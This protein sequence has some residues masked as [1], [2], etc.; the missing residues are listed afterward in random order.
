MATAAKFTEPKGELSL[1]SMLAKARGLDFAR[2]N[3]FE[4]HIFKPPG[5]HS[6]GG[7]TTNPATGA[8][9]KFTNE[10]MRSFSMRCESIT[11]PFRALTTIEDANIYGPTREIASGI[12]YAGDIDLVFQS[13]GNLGERVFFEEWQ[14]QAFNETTWNLNYHKEYVGEIQIFLLDMQDVRK[15][16]VVLHEVYP[17]TING[18]DLSAG[19][20]GIVET[21]VGV[22][23]RWW[24]ALDETRKGYRHPRQIEALDQ[25]SRIKDK[26]LPATKS[27]L[28]YGN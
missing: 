9:N 3:R 17:K 28:N 18:I 14:K 20:E 15:Y 8:L 16:G 22:S 11:M 25:V 23:F 5:A 24:Q 26:N 10:D 12:S 27:R 21:T 19:G 7:A 2:P 13:N 6:S 1:S 4:V